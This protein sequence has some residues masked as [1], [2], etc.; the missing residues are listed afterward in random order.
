MAAPTPSP[1][2]IVTALSELPEEVRHAIALFNARDFDECHHELQA[3]W[4][5]ERDPIRL[6]YQAIVQIGAAALHVQR[7]HW[8]QALTL[9]ARARP[10]L[11]LCPPQWLGVDVARL[12]DD[13]A[14]CEAFVRSLGPERVQ[15]CSMDRFPTIE[16]QAL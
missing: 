9:F 4:Y 14:R 15:G 11:A 1:T 10:K 16:V 7:D 6:L 13:T 12:R 3:V 5:R 8:R 2:T